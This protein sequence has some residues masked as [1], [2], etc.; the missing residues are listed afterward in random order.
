MILSGRKRSA[1]WRAKRRMTR[2]E[3]SGP[4]KIRSAEGGVTLGWFFAMS[5][6]YL[7]TDSFSRE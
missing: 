2:I 5:P 3:T 6:C 1:T 4:Q 7:T